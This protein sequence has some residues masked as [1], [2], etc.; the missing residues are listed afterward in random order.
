MKKKVK[1]IIGAVFVFSAVFAGIWYLCKPVEAETEPVLRADLMDTFTATGTVKPVN[2]SYVCAPFAGKI[3]ELF[4]QAGTKAQKGEA[5]LKIDDSEARGELKDQIA[6]LELQKDGLESQGSAARAELAVT[7]QQLESQ[8]AQVR[9]QYEQLYGENGDAGHLLSI[10]QQNFSSANIA[11]WRAYDEFEDS[12]DPSE[13]A[14]LSA[15]ESARAVAE[16]ALLEAE[17]N[18]SE[19]TRAYYESV[20]A[21]YESQIRLLDSSRASLSEGSNAASEELDIQ[22]GRL[23][24]QLGRETPTAPFG[25]IVWEMLV[26]QGDHVV[27]NQPLYRIYEPDRMEV[28]VSLLDSQAAL[29]KTG[30]AVSLELADGTIVDGKLTF[31]SPISLET[32][33][34]LGIK[35]NRCKAM[36]SVEKLPEQIGAGHQASVTFS[37]LLREQAI[38]IPV[39]ALVSSADGYTVYKVE[40]KRAVLQPVEIG[41]QSNGKVEIL[42]GLEEGDIVVTNFYDIGLKG[43]ERIH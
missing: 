32:L 38:Q 8:L 40:N 23:N 21:S 37:V 25:G 12:H 17:N 16:Q 33:S 24:G 4:M 22:I 28:V 19:S 6:S 13:C 1:M 43:G 9:L 20:I 36:V 29:L 15:L 39:S 26:R 10:A 3:E 5:I 14:Q 31:L 27:E 2:S 7:R 35:E 18:Q 41:K 11:Y 42:E 30:D 34:V